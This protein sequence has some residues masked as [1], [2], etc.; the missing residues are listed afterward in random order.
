[1]VQGYLK[2]ST[3]SLLDAI[4][5]H[6]IGRWSGARGGQ[7]KNLSLAKADGQ[8]ELSRG[9]SRLV[10]NEFELTP[11]VYHEGTVI[12]KLCLEYESLRCLCLSSEAAEVKH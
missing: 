5:R 4:D 12:S 8:T 11:L 9:L 3:T 10:E 2:F 7:V 1:M 6:I